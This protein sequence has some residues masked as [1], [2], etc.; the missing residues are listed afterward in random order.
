MNPHIG[1]GL[2]ILLHTCPASDSME[3]TQI[4]IENKALRRIYGPKVM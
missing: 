4:G 2:P 3:R 1:E